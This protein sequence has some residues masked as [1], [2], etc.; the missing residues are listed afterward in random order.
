MTISS[1]NL[2]FVIAPRSG[3]IDSRPATGAEID[4]GAIYVS[5]TGNDGNSGTA[6][7][8]YRNPAYAASRLAAG[9]TLYFRAGTYDI[10]TSTT[11]RS[12]A[13]VAASNNCTMRA[14]PGETVT[15]RGGRNGTNFGVFPTG[16]TIGTGSRSG[17]HIIG[18]KVQGMVMFDGCPSGSR[19]SRVQD[20]DISVGGD[21]WSGTNQG[22]VVWIDDANNIELI[23]CYL[24]DN[25]I[26]SQST[27]PANNGLIMGYDT[28]TGLIDRCTFRHSAGN[29]VTFKDDVEHLV[30]QNCWFDDIYSS[31]ILTGNNPAD[32]Y[33]WSISIHNNVFTNINTWGTSDWG[34]IQ[35]VI[36]SSLCYA[37]NNTFSASLGGDLI[38]LPGCYVQHAWF[39]NLHHASQ[40]YISYPYAGAISYA[41]YMDYNQYYGAASPRWYHDGNLATTLPAWRTLIQ[42]RLPGAEVASRTDNP[43]FLNGSGTF[44]IPTDFRR[45]AYPAEGRGGTWPT[46][47]GAYVTGSEIIGS[48]L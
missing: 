5:L 9:Q 38:Q 45:V 26:G 18:L 28:H 31:A 8:P 35:F 44:S 32:P 15:L 47:I 23:N 14:Y 37:Y 2:A 10:P 43:N 46:V 3:V 25:D 19:P 1:P 29:G 48:S 24:H 17:T 11:G 41:T 12:C 7:S 33:D 30:I 21:G 39:N 16:G 27:N 4:P 34:V 22:G 42:G 20:C 6:S 36:Q 40:R 13:I